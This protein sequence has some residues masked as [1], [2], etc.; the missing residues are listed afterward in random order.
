MIRFALTI[1][2]ALLVSIMPASAYTVIQAWECGENI[3]VQLNKYSTELNKYSTEGYELNFTGALIVNPR[4]SV[5][6]NFKLI[7]KGATLGATLNG[8]P[9][10]VLPGYPMQENERVLEQ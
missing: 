9:C 1:L 2:A 7:Q 10:H 5:N 8:K 6:Y 3:R 4:P